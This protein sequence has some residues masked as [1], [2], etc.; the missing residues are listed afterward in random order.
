MRVF[1]SSTKGQCYDLGVHNLAG[2]G[3]VQT[4][5]GTINGHKYIDILGNNVWLVIVCHLSDQ[6]L[7]FQDENAPIHRA[8][9]IAN[10]KTRNNINPISWL[11]QSL[12]LNIIDNVWLKRYGPLQCRVENLWTAAELYHAITQ[13]WQALT[14]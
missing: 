14:V 13:G 11:A 1:A 9:Y 3:T 8:R 7:R 6:I 5:E 10:Y 2:V 4:V 12:D